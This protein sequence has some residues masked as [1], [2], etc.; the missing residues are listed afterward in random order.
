M[1]VSELLLCMA[2]LDLRSELVVF[3]KRELIHF[4]QFYPSDFLAMELLEIDDQPEIH[5]RDMRSNNNFLKQLVLV[6]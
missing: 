2:Y 4:D 5:I 3:N 1:I 6:I